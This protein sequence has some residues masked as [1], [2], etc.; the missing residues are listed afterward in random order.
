MY[1][2]KENKGKTWKT[3]KSTQR[4]DFFLYKII[5]QNYALCL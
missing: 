3:R 2:R 4:I 5:N 1:F